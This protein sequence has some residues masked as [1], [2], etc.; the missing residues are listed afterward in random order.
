VSK[1]RFT[2]LAL[3]V[4]GLALA[5]CGSDSNNS[6][7]APAATAISGTVTVQPGSPADP[8]N[9]RA[10]VYTS[11][12]DFNNDA[13]TKQASVQRSGTSWTFTISDLNAGNYYVDVWRDNNNNG[14]ID[15]GDIYGF[16]TT[17]QGGA[18]APVLVNQGSTASVSLQV[19]LNKAVG[20][21][22]R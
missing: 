17:G 15:A 9:A 8:T 12:A 3:L 10:A 21:V 5:G 22:S 20:K 11:L 19:T 13:W 18:P 2:L 6:P 14:A 7:V 16:Y 1:A 4:A